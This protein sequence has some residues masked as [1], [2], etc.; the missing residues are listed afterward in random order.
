[1]FSELAERKTREEANG[2][3]SPRDLHVKRKDLTTLFGRKDT[4]IE[5]I[6]GGKLRNEEICT[7]ILDHGIGEALGC[8]SMG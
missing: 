2:E 3:V 4:M 5:I 8:M 6:S 1:M 7:A